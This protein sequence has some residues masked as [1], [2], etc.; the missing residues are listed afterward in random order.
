MWASYCNPITDVIMNK[1]DYV[2]IQN[3]LASREPA[4][5]QNGD[6]EPDHGNGGTHTSQKST[7]HPEVAITRDSDDEETTGRGGAS[8]SSTAIA[9]I[10]SALSKVATGIK[11]LKVGS[12]HC[13]VT[14]CT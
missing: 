4:A 14:W 9:G 5:A 12:I 2:F 11:G 7:N 6:E 10:G 8:I 3:G 13:I 1:D